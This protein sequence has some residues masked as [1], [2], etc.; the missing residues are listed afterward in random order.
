MR[1]DHGHL[2]RAETSLLTKAA[3]ERRASAEPRGRGA[4][5]CDG[6]RVQRSSGRGFRFHLR[7]L[8]ITRT[9]QVALYAAEP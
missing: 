9:S 1:P 2:A 3:G 5:A 7:F 4:R 6:M 8:L